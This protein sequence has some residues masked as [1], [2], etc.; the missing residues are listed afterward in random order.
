MAEVYVHCAEGTETEEV[1]EA[2]AFLAAHAGPQAGPQ[3]SPQTSPGIIGGARLNLSTVP[4]RG[5]CRCGFSG[6]LRAE[7]LAGHMFVCPRCGCVGEQGPALE[8]VGMTFRDG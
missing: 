2:F 6:E 3:G 7:A 8:L 1:A 4:A 5:A